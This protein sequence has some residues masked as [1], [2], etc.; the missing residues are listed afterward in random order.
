MKRTRS[1]R[2]NVRFHFVMRIGNER[3]EVNGTKTLK[4]FRSWFRLACNFRY[5]YMPKSQRRDMCYGVVEFEDGETWL[6]QNQDH[7][8]PGGWCLAKDPTPF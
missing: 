6:W 1:E 4:L 2:E 3:H 8:F 5:K 7:V